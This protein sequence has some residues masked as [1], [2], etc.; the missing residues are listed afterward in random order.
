VKSAQL[1]DLAIAV[2][3]RITLDSEQELDLVIAAAERQRKSA[4]VRLRVRPDYRDLTTASDF[5]PAMTI[6][7]AANIYKPG[8]EVS[9]AVRIGRRVIEHPRTR[10]TGLMTH[11]GRHSADP[12]VWATMARTFG[13]VVV[14]M[15]DSWAPWRPLELDIGG[16]FP[17]PRDPTNPLRVTAPPLEAFA[18]SAAGALLQTLNAGGVDPAGVVLQVEPG[19]SLLADT[20]IHLSRVCHVKRQNKPVPR[21]WIELDTTE[22]FLADLFM[23]HAYFRPL[24]ASRADAAGVQKVEIVGQSCNF[25]LLARDV[26]APDVA[27]G[28][29]IA[30]LDTGAYQDAAASNFN[31]LTRPATVL[32]TG[33]RCMLIKRRETLEEIFARDLP[34]PGSTR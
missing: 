1:I 15:T 17:S 21:T 24:F 25:D 4:D 34:L 16:G 32:V 29:V 28:D 6:R 5:F 13:S 14:Q 30:F 10:L 3:A 33:D 31:A 7:D 27:N 12:A 11:L 2:E 18:E 8:I 23:E 9:E 19:R 26:D 22:M 20:G